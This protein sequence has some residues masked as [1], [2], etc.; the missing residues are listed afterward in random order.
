MILDIFTFIRQNILLIS[1]A[2]L[3]VVVLIASIF[4]LSFNALR[5]FPTM[6]AVFGLS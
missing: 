1:L 4:C 6:F 3:I 5:L 2:E